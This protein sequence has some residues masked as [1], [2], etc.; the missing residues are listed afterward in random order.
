MKADLHIHSEFS[1]G[2]DSRTAIL[3]KAAACGIEVLA[4]TEHDTTEGWQRSIEVGK[5]Y[6]VKV[7]PGVEISARDYR[8][9][10]KVHILGYDFKTSDAIDALCRPIAEARHE[11]SLQ[12]I[13][14]LQKLGYK[15]TA[16]DVLPYTHKYIFKK[17]ILRYLFDSAQDEKIFGHVYHHIFHGGGPGDFGIKY[18][19]AADAVRAITD[20]GGVAVL[21]HPGQQNN[22]DS[23]PEL[24]AAGLWGIELMHPVHGAYWHKVVREAAKQYGLFCTGGSDYHGIYSEYYHPIGSNL[25]PEITAAELLKYNKTKITRLA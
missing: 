15:I 24:K 14:L 8:T 16:E 12:K 3:R 9:G 19:A 20:C 22:F 13:A 17:H 23:L 25:A 5:N 6:G 4:F 7:L 11:N 2:S 18:A 1:D 21:A 10:K